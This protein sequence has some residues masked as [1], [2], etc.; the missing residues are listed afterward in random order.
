VRVAIVN[1]TLA[2]LIAAQ[3]AVVGE[4]LG[5]DGGP[6]DVQIVGVARDARGRSLKVPPEPTVFRPL[7]QA[8]G[9]SAVSVLLRSEAPQ[10][11]TATAA[12]GI[13]KRI[14]SGVAMRE[15]GRL[16]ALARD[17][18]LRERMLAGLSPVFAGLSA[19]LAEM[20]LFGVASFNVPTGRARLAY[21]WR[22]ARRAAPSRGWS[23]A[24]SRGSWQRARRS[25]SRCSWRATASSVRCCSRCLPTTR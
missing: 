19:I 20:G 17:A 4:T 23:C 15:F 11:I 18:L 6:P 25:A 3:P 13:V 1:E 21:A 22:W 24:R 10:A 16:E 5:F 9:Y 7:A 8:G 2:R 14:D 12:A